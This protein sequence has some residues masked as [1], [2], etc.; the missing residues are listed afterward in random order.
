MEK[1]SKVNPRWTKKDPTKRILLKQAD[2]GNKKPETYQLERFDHVF[3]KIICNY[4]GGPAHV[5]LQN[6]LSSCK[7]SF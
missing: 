3:E 2:S 4:K 1:L 5:S 7:K 6:A